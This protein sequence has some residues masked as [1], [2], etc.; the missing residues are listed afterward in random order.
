[1]SKYL[2]PF[3]LAYRL[4]LSKHY[5]YPIR[6]VT[7]VCFG[8][9]V[10]SSLALCL[11]FAI[12]QGF[13]SS[14]ESK[15]QSIHPQIIMQAA[16][17]TELNLPKIEQH[18]KA[19]FP[20]VTAW[21]PNCIKYAIIQNPRLSSELDL[22][23][24]VQLKGVDPLREPQ[25]SLIEEKLLQS[26]TLEAALQ[27]QQVAIGCK[28]ALLHNLEI[29]DSIIF[30]IPTQ[31]AGQQV[32]FQQIQ[33]KVG[34]IFQ[35]GI[36]EFDQELIITSLDFMHTNFEDCEVTELGL[37]L[38]TDVAEANLISQLSQ[39]FHTTVFSWREP[40]Q[41]IASAL[42]L[43]KYIGLLIAILICL[44][45]SMTLVALLFMLITQHAGSIA[46]LN[47]QG[48]TKFQL[49]ATF[50]VISMIVSGSAASV[51]LALAWIIG[52]ILQNYWII[53]LPDV[54]YVTILPIQLTP[55]IWIAIGITIQIITILM[56]QIPI[57]LINRLKLSQILK[58]NY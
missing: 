8:T 46:I 48:L 4:L 40:Y 54:Y 51:G 12:M 19:H 24:L 28:C 9:I 17:G 13:Q 7:M 27:S 41:A 32:H 30:F 29:N 36:A 23:N 31:V 39:T 34:A 6:I 16:P 10:I 43:E 2:V 14:T 25:V 50:T 20:Q 49:R 52:A 53:E 42:K 58:T 18:L 1:M 26:K 47:T 5:T 56:A 44:I 3:F 55:T 37:K 45:A 38:A 15:L 35:T 22:T 21:A 11:I 57:T 33:S